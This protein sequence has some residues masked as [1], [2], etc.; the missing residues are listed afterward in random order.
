MEKYIFSAV[1]RNFPGHTRERIFKEWH[2]ILRNLYAIYLRILRN[3]YDIYLR[4][5]MYVHSV[6][7]LFGI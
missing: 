4:P 3:F 5:R 6:A 7:F 2:G 1:Q